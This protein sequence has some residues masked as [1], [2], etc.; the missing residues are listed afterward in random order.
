MVSSLSSLDD[1]EVTGEGSEFK[2]EALVCP[3]V[4]VAGLLSLLDFRV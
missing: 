2:S 4:E 1:N 3:L